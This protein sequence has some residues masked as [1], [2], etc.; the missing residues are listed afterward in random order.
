MSCILAFHRGRCS[1][2]YASSCAWLRLASVML[3]Q[4]SWN[5]L[6]WTD[7]KFLVNF[8]ETDLEFKGVAKSIS[9]TVP[10][11]DDTKFFGALYLDNV[12][13]MEPAGKA[14]ILAAGAL[15]VEEKAVQIENE[16]KAL[17]DVT[18]KI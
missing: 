4:F 3:F 6:P 14:K 9:F 12:E 10:K 2:S 17:L 8:N 5:K 16:L 18:H 7:G 15:E 1:S 13:I 11:W